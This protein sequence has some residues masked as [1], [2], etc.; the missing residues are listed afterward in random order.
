MT[1]H[2]GVMVP[3]S[4]CFDLGGVPLKGRPSKLSR[5]PRSRCAVAFARPGLVAAGPR[6]TERE[7]G[8]GPGEFFGVPETGT[9]KQDGNP[10]IMLYIYIYI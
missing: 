4:F 9:S 2:V 7:G 1:Q 6:E 5:L 8:L 10:Y 3:A